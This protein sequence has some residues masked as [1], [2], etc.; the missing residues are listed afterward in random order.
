MA[1]TGK[2]VFNLKIYFCQEEKPE[3]PIFDEEYTGIAVVAESMEEALKISGMGYAEDLLRDNDAK[4]LPIGKV[5]RFEGL[6]RH[7]YGWIEG[8]CPNCKN[9]DEHARLFWD[10]DLKHPYCYD[11]DMN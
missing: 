3:E 9:P 8:K 1:K 7:I 5:D 11:C 6:K 4:D 10:D 2:A